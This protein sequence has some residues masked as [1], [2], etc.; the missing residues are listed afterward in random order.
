MSG[1]KVTFHNQ[2]GCRLRHMNES[3]SGKGGPLCSCVGVL[4]RQTDLKITRE[5]GE[6]KE[7]VA[8]YV[9]TCWTF[10]WIGLLRK[11]VCLRLLY[12]VNSLWYK[13]RTC[14]YRSASYH[15]DELVCVQWMRVSW[16]TLRFIMTGTE[17]VKVNLP[18]EQTPL[19]ILHWALFHCV[20]AIELMLKGLWGQTVQSKVAFLLLL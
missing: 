10:K 5:N 8:L 18:A 3:M 13:K 2:T 1:V 17:E 11:L 6:F 19:W 14:L 16:W 12:F 9:L 4:I 7:Q 15:L 20:H